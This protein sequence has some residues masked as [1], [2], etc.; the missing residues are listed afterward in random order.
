MPEST[1]LLE[2]CEQAIAIAQTAGAQQAAAGASTSRSVDFEYRDGKLEKVQEATSRSLGVQLYV[3]GRYSSHSTTDLRPERLQAFIDEAVALTRALQPD[4]HRKL[5]EDYGAIARLHLDLVDDSLDA[6]SE[7]ERIAWC[8]EM[9]TA[10]HADDQVISS[11]SGVSQAQN[12]SARVTSNGF[13]GQHASTSLWMGTEV[14]LDDPAGGRPEAWCWTGGHHRDDPWTPTAMAAEALRL[15]KDRLG[16]TKGPSKK[17]TMVV[18]PRAGRRLVGALLR[19]ANARSI[20]Q[21]RS[22]WAGQADQ[23]LFSDQLTIVDD[24]LR[25]RGLA[26]RHYDGEGLASRKMTVVEAGVVREVYVD[27][28]YGRK[29]GMTPTTGSASN[30][31]VQPGEGDL[32]AILA[33]V[34]EC[35]YVTSWLGGNHDDTTGDFSFG[36]RGHAI[37]DGEIGPPIGEMNITGNLKDLFASLV[38]VGDDPWVFSTTLTPTMVFEGV[39]FSGA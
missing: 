6:L 27:T 16:S 30:R 18:D 17:T 11:T 14:T 38:R 37:E 21:G 33:D 10:L 1:E 12:A 7:D 22:F 39:Q 29:A 13:A 25:V 32:A 34:G 9:D 8:A 15:C 23:K 5:P 28:Y 31:I 36:L 19:G 26:S 3:D 2:R 35:I 4:E 20:Q 24:P